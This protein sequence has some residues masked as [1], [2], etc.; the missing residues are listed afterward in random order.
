MLEK[1]AADAQSG[2]QPFFVG[3]GFHQPHRPWHMPKKFWVSP[4]LWRD[5]GK[6][7]MKGEW[8]GITTTQAHLTHYMYL[9][10]ICLAGLI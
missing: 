6:A 8:T 10:P 5:H 9:C 4:C 7:G 3:V 1:A 2:D